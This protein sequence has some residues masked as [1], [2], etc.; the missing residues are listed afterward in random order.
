MKKYPIA[1]HFIHLNA[2]NETIPAYWNENKH[3]IRSF[4]IQNSNITTIGI[5]AFNTEAFRRLYYLEFDGIFVKQLKNGM[6]NGLTSL[7]VL[8]LRNLNVHTF[9]FNSFIPNQNSALVLNKNTDIY[10]SLDRNV[11]KRNYSSISFEILYLVDSGTPYSPWIVLKKVPV[12]ITTLSI[13]SILSFSLG[14]KI[15]FTLMHT[16]QKIHRNLR[17]FVQNLENDAVA[18]YV[19]N[20][21]ITYRT[22]IPVKRIKKVRFND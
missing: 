6:F 7:K 19:Q 17:N 14:L 10:Q 4:C 21:F 8:I 9:H 15:S 11:Q 2:Q 12:I 16:F 1:L 13:S 18:M 22:Y 3:N 5:N 20:D